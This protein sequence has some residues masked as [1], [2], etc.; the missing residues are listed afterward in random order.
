LR[1]LKRVWLQF[2]QRIWYEGPVWFLPP[3]FDPEGFSSLKKDEDIVDRI[4]LKG[5]SVYGRIGH[6]GGSQQLIPRPLRGASLGFLGGL[7]HALFFRGRKANVE[8]DFLFAGG[9]FWASGFWHI[10]KVGRK[11][12]YMRRKEEEKFEAAFNARRA[13][14]K[15]WEEFE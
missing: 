13:S 15:A 1:S 10:I 6:L 4:P 3:V 11:A 8:D 9:E 5:R 7:L 14:L 2:D 12:E